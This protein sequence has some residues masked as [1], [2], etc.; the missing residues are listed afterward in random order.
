[1]TTWDQ[2]DHAT[3]WTNA[4]NGTADVFATTGSTRSTGQPDNALGNAAPVDGGMYA[5]F[6]ALGP[7]AEQL[8][9][10]VGRE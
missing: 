2:L 4:N 10:R 5:G 8:A 3:G 7:A 6:V 9:S 1:M